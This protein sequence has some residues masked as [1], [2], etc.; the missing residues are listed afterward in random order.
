[1]TGEIQTINPSNVI[2]KNENSFSQSYFE[3][4]I[5]DNR[6]MKT[7]QSNYIKYL[8]YFL[9]WTISEGIQNPI[10]DDIRNY[11]K[12]LDS[13]ISERTGKHLEETTK[14][15]YFQVVKTFFQFLENENLYSNITKGIKSF[16]VD[17]EERKRPFTE[18]EIKVIFNSIDKTTEKGKRDSS[19][20]L[21]AVENGLRSI[22]IERAN[23]EDLETIDNQKRLYIQGKGK[24]EK[25]I[26]VN[27][28]EELSKLL[29]D[30]LSTRKPKSNN[31]PLFT[32]TGN[33]NKGKRIE[34]NTISKLFKKIFKQS[35]FNSKKLTFH[36]LRHTS[37]TTFYQIT[38]DT[39][40][41]KKHQRHESINSTM[42]YIHDKE[43]TEDKS[44]QMIHDY[45]FKPKEQTIKQSLFTQIE[46][47]SEEN[48]V[49]LNDYIMTLKGSDIQS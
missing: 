9:Q 1:M 8:K 26:F 16:K 40:Q 20:L 47:L 15:Q 23:L 24:T 29:D 28:S 35:G 17:K 44:G 14:Q 11:Q 12:H 6:I 32:T 19:I 49:K 5:N 43:A 48:L 41:V 13:I 33:R 37:G 27:L 4:F 7:T 10:R 34:R 46:S 21:L 36:S 45:I 3:K 39:F 18:E 2:L 30:Y 31:E 25:N 42:I 22:E 38:N